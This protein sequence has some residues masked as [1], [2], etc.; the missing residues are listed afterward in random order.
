MQTNFLYFCRKT[1]THLTSYIQEQ[2]HKLGFD[3]CGFAKA[4]PLPKNEVE[5]IAK[6]LQ[7]NRNGEMSYMARNFEKRIDPTKLVEGCKSVIVVALNYYPTKNLDLGTLK[8][9]RFAHGQDY[10]QIIRGKL[11]NLLAQIQASG[12]N[13]KGRGFSDSAPIA[14]RYWAVQAG[15]GWIGKNQMVILPGMGSYFFLGVLFVD[16]ELDYGTPSPNRCG[17]CNRCQMACPTKALD[18]QGLDARKCLSYL[19]IEKSGH[20]N[21]EE[22]AHMNKKGWIFGCDICQEVCPW[23]RYSKPH[24]NKELKPSEAFLNL[25]ISDFNN[26]TIDQFNQLFSNT[27]LERT[28]FE[29]IKR[30]LEASK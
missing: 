11:S 30:N 22:A 16:L 7:A 23:N 13:V 9:A 5:K 20:F 25:S 10:H 12:V 18:H 8:V 19:T 27:C 17:K 21:V 2:A 15:L 6:W 14:E 24:Q 26:L 1:T 29:G 3:A 4:A 28:G